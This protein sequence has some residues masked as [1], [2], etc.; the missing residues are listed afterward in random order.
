MAI[1][2]IRETGSN[3]AKENLEVPSTYS[4]FPVSSPYMP[5]S[6]SAFIMDI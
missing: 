6:P 2:E 5:T 1:D 4:C 3:C